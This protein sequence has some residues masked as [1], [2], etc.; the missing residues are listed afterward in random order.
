MCTP[1]ARQNRWVGQLTERAPGDDGTVT[2]L[3]W[4]AVFDPA[5][6]IRALGAV[7]SQGLRAATEIVDRFVQ[8]A[9][10]G[11]N[12]KASDTA[13]A[14]PVDKPIEKGRTSQTSAANA[15]R[16]LATWESLVG[17]LARTVATPGPIPTGI[18]TL[19]LA[20]SGATTAIHMETRDVGPVCAEVWL[21]N[22][23]AT[24][25]G[26]IGLRCSDLLSHSGDVIKAGAVCFEPDPV[27][28]PARSSRGAI[29]TVQVAED[30]SPG[31]Y[32]GT[33]LV[34]GHPQLWLPLVL[35]L[36]PA[37]G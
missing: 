21:H 12:H 29:V 18:P 37:D 31:V 23:G 2:D 6:N 35:T 28:M 34:D 19:D 10:N 9:G 26:D 24:N 22:G 15:D 36:Q 3:P 16:V 8:L 32:R 7:Q 4:A 33:L 1:I 14:Q 30:V 20:G 5:A 13:D 25:L 17:R 27:P 11:S